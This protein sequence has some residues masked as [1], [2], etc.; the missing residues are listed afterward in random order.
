MPVLGLTCYRTRAGRDVPRGVRTCRQLCAIRRRDNSAELEHQ[1]EVVADCP[2]FCDTPITKSIHE[3]DVSFV[4]TLRNVEPAK[5]PGWPVSGPNAVL[6]DVITLGDD[7]AFDPLTGM[8]LSAGR[9]KELARTFD[10]IRAS[11]RERVVYDI[12]CA[13]D[14]ELAQVATINHLTEALYDDFVLTNA[15]DGSFRRNVP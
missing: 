11:R 10:A 6:D 8:S 9:S 1:S 5:V 15:H 7:H 12:W 14:V 2:T 4:V 3:R 13:E